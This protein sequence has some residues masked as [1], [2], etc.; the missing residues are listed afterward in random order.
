MKNGGSRHSP[1][2]LKAGF[3]WG[4]VLSLSSNIASVTTTLLLVGEDA[5]RETRQGLKLPSCSC[6]RELTVGM[7]H[8]LGKS[9]LFSGILVLW[10]GKI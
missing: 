10:T 6:Q 5:L 3:E 1:S 4:K 8:I 7:K 2:Y 9:D